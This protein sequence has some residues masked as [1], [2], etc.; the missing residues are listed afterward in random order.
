MLRCRM[1][2]DPRKEKGRYRKDGQQNALLMLRDLRLHGN[3]ATGKL[4]DEES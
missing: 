3:E 4:G 1:A 2:L